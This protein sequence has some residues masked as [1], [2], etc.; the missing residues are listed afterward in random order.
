MSATGGDAAGGLEVSGGVGGVTATTEAI[1]EAGTALLAVGRDVAGVLPELSAIARH[2]ALALAAALDP[3]GAVRVAGA[4]AA[5]L[6]GESG[7]VPAAAGCVRL[8][9]SVHVAAEVYRL[10][11]TEAERL[12]SAAWGAV[13][14]T[15]LPAVGRAAIGLAPAVVGPSAVVVALS[16][17]A[18]VLIRGVPVLASTAQQAAAAAAASEL[19]PARAALLWQQAD[20]GVRARLGDDLTTLALAAQTLA[21]RHPAVVR[22]A[23]SALPV[24]LGGVVPQ[25]LQR[26]L[27]EVSV[28]GGRVDLVPDTVPEVAGFGAAAAALVGVARQ[29]RVMVAPVGPSRPV[30]APVDVSGLVDRLRPSTPS[31]SDQQRGPYTPGRIRLDRVEAD[32]GPR[33]VLYLPPTQTWSIS[34]GPLPADGT[35]NVRMVGGLDSDALEGARAVLREAGVGPED[36]VLAVGYSQGGIAAAALAAD[37]ATPG[38]VEAVLTL[39]SPVSHVA[40]PAGV[41]TLSLENAGDLTPQLDGALDP[42]L[43]HRT[44]VGRDLPVD[45]ADPWAGHQIGAYAETARLV[46][47]STHP[48]VVGWREQVAPFLRPDGSI[49]SQE[50]GTR[51]ELP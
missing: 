26:V 3:F 40:L 29:G 51:R 30:T 49:S 18:W 48:S 23:I 1:H 44:S 34:G 8:G 36:P 35:A 6:V 7:L 41:A 28:E 31:T 15:V 19:G 16:A 50:Y 20:A 13:A 42:D 43:A 33:W 45:P 47:L 38:R 9:T 21:A 2:P 14:P 32:G 4:T 37:P 46:D 27:G 12:V 10:T 22:E 17:S 11:E 39:G 25:Q 5:A 24:A